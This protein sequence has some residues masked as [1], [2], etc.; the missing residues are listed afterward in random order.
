MSLYIRI[1]VIAVMPLILFFT[2]AIFQVQSTVRQYSETLEHAWQ[3]KTANIQNN[4]EQIVS[5]M[6]KAADVLSESDEISRGLRAADNEIL[7]D[8]S[9]KFID[10]ITSIV[11]ADTSGLVIARAPHEFEFGDS[12]SDYHYF[13]VVMKKGEY[14]GAFFNDDTLTLVIA[15]P[16]KQYDDIMIGMVGI[17]VHVNPELL[18]SFSKD[19]NIR[20]EMTLQGRSVQ[21]AL[22]LATTVQKLALDSIISQ[23]EQEA[24]Q[25]HVYFGKDTYYARLLNMRASLYWGSLV[26]VLILGVLLVYLL[27][28]IKTHFRQIHQYNDELR[29][30]NLVLDQTNQQLEDSLKKVKKLSGLLPICAYCKKIRDD[31]GYWN[32]LEAYLL[33]HSEAKFSH[34]ICEDCM[35][36]YHQELEPD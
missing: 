33:E 26:A 4:I 36:K 7:F 17:L 19:E 8:I 32:Q 14:Q 35:K 23:N 24:V 13:K 1:L 31:T 10:P 29:Q 3:L 9:R 18:D 5:Q 30:M 11:F 20:L 34:G 27:T 15:K 22:H 28:L 25:V 6:D 12:I 21:S 2:A 16:I